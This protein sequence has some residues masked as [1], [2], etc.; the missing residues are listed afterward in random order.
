MTFYC[1]DFIR[2][3]IKWG[4]KF[5]VRD[6]EDQISSPLCVIYD[7]I[8]FWIFRYSWG[9]D[10]IIHNILGIQFSK[11]IHFCWHNNF[12]VYTK[13]LYER[14][15]DQQQFLCFKNDP[16]KQHRS[17]LKAVQ[18]YCFSLVIRIRSV[19]KFCTIY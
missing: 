2:I 11:D 6:H 14:Q 8:K 4:S 5:P 19:M 3:V 13:G 16:G 12:N 7:H 9:P 10:Y 17:L 18:S 1:R 15:F